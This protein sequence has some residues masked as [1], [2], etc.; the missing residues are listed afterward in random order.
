MFL[1]YDDVSAHMREPLVHSG[2]IYLVVAALRA[3]GTQSESM[4]SLCMR[5]LWNLVD[6]KS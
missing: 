6:G 1:P 5:A 2:A 4:T 3:H